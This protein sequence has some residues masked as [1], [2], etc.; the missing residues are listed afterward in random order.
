MY[1]SLGQEQNL[2]PT[3]SIIRKRRSTLR[4]N[5]VW[6]KYPSPMVGSCLFLA[7]WLFFEGQIQNPRMAADLAGTAIFTFTGGLVSFRQFKPVSPGAAVIAGVIGGFLTA[8][9][10][11][12]FRT[13]L[14]G[15][16]PNCLFWITDRFYWIAIGQGL[17]LIL[18][19]EPKVCAQCEACWD[20]A[21]RM[22]L[23]V[24]APL[25]A[26]KAV[27][28]GAENTLS[29][30][31]MAAF[32]GFLTGAGG[33]A[34]RDLMRIRLPM[35]F[36]TTYGWVA[37][38]GGVFHLALLQSGVPMTWVVSAVV[39]YLIAESMHQWNGAYHGI[40]DKERPCSYLDVHQLI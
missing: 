27:L 24:F 23:A 3:P 32:F 8:V 1:Q 34:L 15:L 33:G 6:R 16:E 19:W 20:V 7:F 9:G 25:G 5:L 40:G 26:E 22:A 30:I 18:L 14:L 39:I 38:F 4:F 12:T 17:F 10:G 2:N 31:M 36:F 11:G 13:L 37:A 29:L 21:D 35:A 28:W